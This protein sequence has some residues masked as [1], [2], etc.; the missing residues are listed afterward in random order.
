MRPE[1]FAESLK[2]NPP[3]FREMG[4]NRAY[5]MILEIGKFYTWLNMDR[6]LRS[7]WGRKAV[8]DP[9]KYS[10]KYSNGFTDS[11]VIA[12]IERLDAGFN[13]LSND[14]EKLDY[15]DRILRR[16]QIATAVQDETLHKNEY[17][18]L[19][20][21][22]P[23]ITEMFDYLEKQ[24]CNGAIYVLASHFTKVLLT[25]ATI[26]KTSHHQLIS[27]DKALSRR[28]KQLFS[29]IPEIYKNIPDILKALQEIQTENKLPL[30]S[31]LDIKNME[32]LISKIDNN[33]IQDDGSYLPIINQLFK[34][35]HTLS[36]QQS[37]SS[38]SLLF[39]NYKK[40]LS[41]LNFIITKYAVSKKELIVV[42]EHATINLDATGLHA[43]MPITTSHEKTDLPAEKPIKDLEASR[44]IN[45]ILALH[46]MLKNDG[47][48][49]VV[50]NKE[51]NEAKIK[52]L[53][54]EDLDGLIEDKQAISGFDAD[55]ECFISKIFA[56]AQHFITERDK[57]HAELVS[58]EELQSPVT[59][60]TIP[61]MDH[62]ELR[63]IIRRSLTP[64]N[65]WHVTPTDIETKTTATESVPQSQY[66][67]GFEPAPSNQ[68]FENPNDETNE[69]KIASL[70]GECG[71]FDNASN[72]VTLA[73]ANSLDE[74]FKP[75]V[76]SNN[77]PMAPISHQQRIAVETKPVILETQE[78]PGIVVVEKKQASRLTDPLDAFF[79][80]IPAV[81]ST[82]LPTPATEEHARVPA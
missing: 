51:T 79:A 8:F 5:R 32:R 76:V 46:A 80:A 50:I 2:N 59:L 78:R 45:A 23:L 18:V 54:Q 48:R 61:G 68:S 11:T 70:L 22:H 72:R 25:C 66:T 31:D 16:N 39:L 49:V 37:K 33:S 82:P 27:H 64:S 34:K 56:E 38:F 21:N 4:I 10:E 41:F 63:E 36:E 13:V 17:A 12:L 14:E 58:D 52:N 6:P 81:P 26:K 57:L 53:I 24:N 55:T 47:K 20:T 9:R 74:Y 30:F 42:G 71:L 77:D 40:E 28:I 67:P 69:Q 73:L 29:A 15:L 44:F 75:P 35:I 3:C 65:G 43:P 7:A 1:E 60:V 19:S 62:E